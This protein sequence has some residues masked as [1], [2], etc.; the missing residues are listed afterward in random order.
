MRMTVYENYSTELM[1][2]LRM[3]ETQDHETHTLNDDARKAWL[4]TTCKGHCLLLHGKL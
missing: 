1:E 3:D 4:S 2:N